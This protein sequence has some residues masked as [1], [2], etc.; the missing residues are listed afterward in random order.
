MYTKNHRISKQHNLLKRREYFYRH[1]LTVA[2]LAGFATYDRISVSAS[3]DDSFIVVY[4][5]C[6]WFIAATKVHIRNSI[7]IGLLNF[8]KWY[9]FHIA[10]TKSRR[11]YFTSSK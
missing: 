8:S 9:S 2:R 5:G 7:N 3:I 10:R 1:I 11:D 4:H 6:I